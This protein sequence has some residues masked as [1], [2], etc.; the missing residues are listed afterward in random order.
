MLIGSP[1]TLLA[2]VFGFV[3]ES[4]VKS[5]VSSTSC[6]EVS[7]LELC[8]RFKSHF[9]P[10]VQTA[11]Y[12]GCYGMI[13]ENTKRNLRAEGAITVEARKAL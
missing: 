11:K 10:Q 7:E 2:V 4:S 5:G 13:E 6:D 9:P 3:S 12:V 1:I 8:K